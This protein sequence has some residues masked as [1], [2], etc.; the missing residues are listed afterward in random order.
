MHQVS[1]RVAD[2]AVSGGVPDRRRGTAVTVMGATSTRQD[3]DGGS[4]ERTGRLQDTASRFSA[5]PMWTNRQAS[6][7]HVGTFLG[8]PGAP[9]S[10][11]RP[12]PFGRDRLGGREGTP[13]RLSQWRGL[14]EAAG[15]RRFRPA[16]QAMPSGA[17]RRLTDLAGS[18]APGFVVVVGFESRYGSSSASCRVEYVCALVSRALTVRLASFTSPPAITWRWNSSW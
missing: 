13:G 15:R 5:Q 6:A 16:A 12:A 4:A 11:L 10:V 3:Q 18:L 17:D 9:A 2:R 1:L 8:V 14:T 7:G